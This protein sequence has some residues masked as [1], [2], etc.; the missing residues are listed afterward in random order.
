MTH[1]EFYIWLDGFLTNRCWTFVKESDIDAIKEKMKDVKGEFDKK[2][3]EK[4]EK[5]LTINYIITDCIEMGIYKELQKTL[6]DLKVNRKTTIK[7]ELR[8]YRKAFKEIT[9][10]LD[11]IDEY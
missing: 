10:D 1:K 7:D 8:L 4:Y 2:E 6:Y 3:Y 11:Y 9:Q 5:S